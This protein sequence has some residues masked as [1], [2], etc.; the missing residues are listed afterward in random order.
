MLEPL[1][2]CNLACIGCAVERHT[3]KLKDRLPLEKCIEAVEVSGAPIVSICGGE[4]T[5]YPGAAAAR[6]RDHQAQAPD[7]PLHERPAARRDGVRRDP[8]HKRLTIN[9]HLDGMRETHDHVC[10]R[11][12][13]FDKAIAMIREGVKLGPP[14]DG[15]HDRSSRRR[16]RRR[17][18][19]SAR[20]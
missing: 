9:V 8:A 16:R 14:H 4:P 5:I 11:K 13:V 12:G 7:H 6:G 2:T 15:Q 20:C 10:A 17:S 1:Y 19:S 3:G 18:R